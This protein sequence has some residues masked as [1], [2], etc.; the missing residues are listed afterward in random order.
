[1][2]QMHMQGHPIVQHTHTHTHTGTL[3]SHEKEQSNA[4]SATW[5]QLEMIILKEVSQK[6][7]NK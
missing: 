5:M 1:M 2:W 6:E 3:L 7:K 4:T